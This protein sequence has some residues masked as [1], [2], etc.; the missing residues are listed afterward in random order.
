MEQSTA[1]PSEHDLLVGIAEQHAKVRD[2]VNDMR[3]ASLSGN[4]MR[5]GQL[6]RELLALQH[7]RDGLHDLWRR[8]YAGRPTSAPT[9][10]LPTPAVRL[11]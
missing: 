11:G 9:P 6:Q 1:M 2:T 10:S 4:H 8:L 7:Q 3:R 5:R